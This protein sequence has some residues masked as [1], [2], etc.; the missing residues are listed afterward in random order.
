MRKP[1]LKSSFAI[2][3]ADA[4]GA[5][6]VERRSHGLWRCTGDKPVGQGARSADGR[7][8]AQAFSLKAL[9][10]PQDRSVP[11][12]RRRRFD[13]RAGKARMDEIPPAVQ[14]AA[15]RGL[16]TCDDKALG[17]SGHGDVEQTAMFARLSLSRLRPRCG[18][19]VGVLER[20]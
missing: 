16:V 6:R 8:F 15:L 20:L 14:R 7:G 1:S 13:E 3:P 2:A 11:A 12:K 4:A 9:A 5:R 18:D 19:L 10:K 17:C